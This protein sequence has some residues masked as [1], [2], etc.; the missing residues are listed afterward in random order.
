MQNFFDGFVSDTGIRRAFVAVLGCLALFLLVSTF[1]T[2]NGFGRTQNPATDVITVTGQG[3]AT[4]KP[5]VARLVV[6]IFHTKPAVSDAQEETTKQTNDTIAFLKTSGIAEK[7]I[8]TTSYAITPHYATYTQ[9]CLPGGACPM[10]DSR[11]TGYDVSQTIELKVRDLT[12]VSSILSGLGKLNVQ[13]V[14][15]PNFGLEDESAG[16]SAARA[17]AIEKAKAQAK[18]LSAELGVRLV[19]IINFSENV[20]GTPYPV[21]Y[22]MGGVMREAKAE[23]APVVPAGEN[24]YSASVSITYEIR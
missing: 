14:S 13:N 19:K 17:V 12:K 22:A 3:E 16:Q 8:R 4:V 18:E 15:G 1:A 21:A 20:S 24:T 2:F 10:P 6:T 7:D 5:D 11:I 9:A 23:S